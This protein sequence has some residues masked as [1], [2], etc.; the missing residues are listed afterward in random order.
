MYK[1]YLFILVV[2]LINNTAFSQETFPKNG[3]QSKF[4]PIHAF[5]NAYIIKAPGD[6]IPKGTMLIQG[7]R[8]LSVDSQLTIPKG[9]II[10]QMDGI[11]FTPHS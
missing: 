3:V 4:E 7:D 11:T 6:V 2:F 1:I 5:T 10:H 9:A 8:I